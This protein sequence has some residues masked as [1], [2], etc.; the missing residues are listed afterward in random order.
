MA[1]SKEVSEAVFSSLWNRL[2]V[3]KDKGRATPAG[4]GVLGTAGRGESQKEL[5]EAFG[6]VCSAPGAGQWLPRRL[7]HLE[8]PAG[9]SLK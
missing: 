4:G 8:L 1:S 9:L 6:G 7:T 3:F 5:V 2:P